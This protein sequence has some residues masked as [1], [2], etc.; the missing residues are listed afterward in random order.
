MWPIPGKDGRFLGREE[1]ED[2]LVTMWQK[3]S[4]LFDLT[5]KTQSNRN[6]FV[7]AKNET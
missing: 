7:K 4:C 6:A 1:R 3:R 5:A 2:E